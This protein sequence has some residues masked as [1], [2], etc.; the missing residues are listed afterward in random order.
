MRV[1]AHFHASVID[2]TRHAREL[3][4]KVIERRDGVL[5][6][7]NGASARIQRFNYPPLRNEQSIIFT[8]GRGTTV[9]D[10]RVLEQANTIE[11]KSAPVD[12]L[13][14]GLGLVTSNVKDPTF[15]VG[16]ETTVVVD[17]VS[18]QVK[19]LFHEDEN[20]GRVLPGAF[21]H[22]YW[23][24]RSPLLQ[25]TTWEKFM[26]TVMLGIPL[27]KS[28]TFDQLLLG[29]NWELVPG[30]E[31][32]AGVHYAKVTRLAKGFLVGD[33]I[34]STL[35]TSTITFK[36]YRPALFAGVVLNSDAFAR[37]VADRQR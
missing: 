19:R 10:L 5:K 7:S 8:I 24:R 2:E 20:N 28:D 16:P 21:I 23:G 11:L 36:Q 31:L 14:F 3:V 18:M 4:Q 33:N 30:V 27:A 1:L 35:D 12:S 9:G 17:N 13:R 15:K 37:L 25:P 6:A 29:L 26:P 32:G 34:P 22:N